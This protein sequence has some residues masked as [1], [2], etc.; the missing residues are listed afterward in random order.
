M[1]ERKEME[2]TRTVGRR[3]GGGANSI[4]SIGDDM[5]GMQLEMVATSSEIREGKET[6][7]EKLKNQNKN[8]GKGSETN[9]TTDATVVNINAVTVSMEEEGMVEWKLQLR[10]LEVA[11]KTTDVL[12]VFKALHAVVIEYT[13]LKTN[14]KKMELIK[15]C[16]EKKAR[17]K[18]VWTK[19][20]AV[21]F[22]KVLQL[23]QE[24]SLLA[25]MGMQTPAVLSGGLRQISTVLRNPFGRSSSKEE[26]EE[27]EDDDDLVL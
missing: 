24:S 23:Y 11:E 6:K 3:I 27:K 22:R 5:H 19:E 18:T 20:V 15:N 25:V 26:E 1:N 17:N 14:E 21:E 2:H 12:N 13:C 9:D 7:E 10:H 8:E 16:K 4:T